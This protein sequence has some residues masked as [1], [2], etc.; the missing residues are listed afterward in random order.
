ML[1][2]LLPNRRVATW[3]K[4]KLHLLHFK[5]ALLNNFLRHPLKPGQVFY[6]PG[7]TFKY[8]VVGA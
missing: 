2:T 1:Y 8:R 6:S 5:A 3:K 4:V 7:G